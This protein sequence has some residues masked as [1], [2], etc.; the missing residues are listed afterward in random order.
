VRVRIDEDYSEEA[1]PVAGGPLYE[2][3]WPA[4]AW[5]RHS[6]GRHIL[7]VT[8]TDAANRT[9]TTSHTFALTREDA[10]P[11]DSWLANL[12][13]RSSFVAVFHALFALTL[14]GNLAAMLLLRLRPCSFIRRAGCRPQ[15]CWLVRRLA[16]V[17]AADR[18]FY[19]LLCWVVYTAAGPWVLGSLIEGRAGAV[20]AWGVVMVGGAAP[21]SQ[22]TFIW[23]FLHLGVIHPLVVTVLGHLLHWRASAARAPALSHAL[24][25]L[26]LLLATAVSVFFSLSFWLHFG[27][28]GFFLGPLK[29]WSYVFYPLLFYLA[30]T[31][32]PAQGAVGEAR[33]GETTSLKS[34]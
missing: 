30:W 9:T 12:V 34:A 26:A 5:A 33:A 4:A 28:L 29:T 23:Y 13:L 7:T 3:P 18:L 10:V 24:A 14:L 25:A 11:V 19:P 20:F 15:R 2:A 6:T 1:A 27:A 8:A 21:H 22:T 31:L 16:L 17:M 32:P